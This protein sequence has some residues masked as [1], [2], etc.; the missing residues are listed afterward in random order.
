M[1]VQTSQPV[2]ADGV[3]TLQLS[4]T[5]DDPFAAIVTAIAKLERVTPLDLDP[6]DPRITST[7]AIWP[8]DHEGLNELRLL[9]YGYRV[10]VRD[11]GFVTI[12]K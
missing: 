2:D 11:D 1:T 7:L 8:L 9:A 4:E 12:K 3:H 10:I 5:E 6:L